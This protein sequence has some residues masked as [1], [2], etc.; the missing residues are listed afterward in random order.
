[1]NMSMCFSVSLHNIQTEGIYI[2][3]PVQLLL[4]EQNCFYSAYLPTCLILLDHNNLFYGLEE[5]L[6][7]GITGTPEVSTAQGDLCLR[8]IRSSFNQSECCIRLLW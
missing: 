3:F 4:L 5:G 7:L 8:V 1:M 2:K 6:I